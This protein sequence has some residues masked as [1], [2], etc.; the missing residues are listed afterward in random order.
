MMAGNLS[1]EQRKW[2]ILYTVYLLLA[3]LVCVYIYIYI[4]IYIYKRIRVIYVYS[5]NK[6]S[7][8]RELSNGINSLHWHLKASPPVGTALF[9]ATFVT[10]SL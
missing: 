9:I 10:P 6:S 8:G 3:H 4:Y 1:I 5:G 7:F 2:I